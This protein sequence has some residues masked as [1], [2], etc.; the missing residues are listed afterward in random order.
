MKTFQTGDL[1]LVE[2]QAW[3]VLHHQVTYPFLG[4]A[5][6]IM[7]LPDGSIQTRS[8]WV[9]SPTKKIAE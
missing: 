8:V 6:Y 1:V 3:T 9:D 7:L 5:N 2:G 4:I